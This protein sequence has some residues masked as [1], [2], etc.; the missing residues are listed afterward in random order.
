MVFSAEL[1]LRV[2]FRSAATSM[3]AVLVALV[4]WPS[5]VYTPAI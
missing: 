5:A 1:R 3:I 2:M 4:L